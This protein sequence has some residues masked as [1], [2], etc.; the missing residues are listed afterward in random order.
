[1]KRLARQYPIPI[2]PS[3]RGGRILARETASKKQFGKFGS[4]VDWRWT[5]SCKSGTIVLTCFLYSQRLMALATFTSRRETKST[6]LAV[7]S[8]NET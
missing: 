1:M 2:V 4:L 5:H 3:S 7:A 6:A 8:R